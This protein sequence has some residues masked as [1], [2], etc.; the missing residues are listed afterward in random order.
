MTFTLAGQNALRIHYHATTDQ[1][2]VINMTNHSYFNLAGQA[3]GS[4]LNQR[5]MIN[6]NRYTPTNSV[7]IP[8]GQIDSVLGTPMD[9][10]HDEGDRTRHHQF[11]PAAGARARVRPQ[12]GAQRSGSG[13]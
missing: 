9:F 6:A 5:L 7:Q 11:L 3:S 1:P 10:R 2:T 13:L 8:T 12:L 4:I